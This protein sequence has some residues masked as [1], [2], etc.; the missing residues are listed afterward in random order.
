MDVQKLSDAA[1]AFSK[2]KAALKQAKDGLEVLLEM[3]RHA[4]RPDALGTF[5]LVVEST[6]ALSFRQPPPLDKLIAGANIA[7][8][9]LHQILP[10]II[11]AQQG[12]VTEL[13]M[14]MQELANDLVECATA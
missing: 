3:Q 8:V 14:E 10:L 12:Q 5:T 9:L 7:P 2:K 1:D 11:A 13:E 6:P 4:D